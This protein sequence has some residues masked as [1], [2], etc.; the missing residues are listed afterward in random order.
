MEY[1][2]G[3]LVA[4]IVALW[5]RSSHKEE[6]AWDKTL[7]RIKTETDKNNKQREDTIR[8]AKNLLKRI[9]DYNNDSDGGDSSGE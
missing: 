7:H 9:D 5:L 3:A 2:V 4:I 8:D 1:V 6:K